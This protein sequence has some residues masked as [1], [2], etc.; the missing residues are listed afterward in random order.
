M[1]IYC[2]PPL[3]QVLDWLGNN[4]C[5]GRSNLFFNYLYCTYM[6]ST[7]LY[8]LLTHIIFKRTLGNVG[9]MIITLCTEEAEAQ[10]G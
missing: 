2:L 7:V 9:T 8:I 6:S 5:L 3:D 1:N 10:R 4:W